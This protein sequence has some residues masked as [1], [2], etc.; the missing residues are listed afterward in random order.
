ME[1]KTKQEII[2]YIDLLQPSLAG[3][4]LYYCLPFRKKVVLKNMNIVFIDVLDQ[5]QIKNLALAFYSNIAKSL[6]ENLM[7]RF[8]SE[9]KIKSKAKVLGTEYIKQVLDENK[10]VLV[11]TG[12]FGNWE[13]A[14]IAGI[15][16]FK[17]LQGRFY[18]IR[19]L[20]VNKFFEKLLFS[21]YYNAGLNVIPKKN[22]LIKACEALEENSAVV[23]VMDQ[24]GCIGSK[25]GIKANFFGKPAGTYRS[26]A[27]I[28]RNMEVP[29]V[30]AQ[31]Y[32]KKNGTHVLEFHP[33]L[34]WIDAPKGREALLKNT[35]HYN[36][37]LEGMILKYPEQWLWMHKR[38]KI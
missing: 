26:L 38:W 31:S 33:P 17:M 16:N 28:A 3:K 15:L 25:D 29:V 36:H 6:K 8:W 32:R 10:G 5:K 27:T 13:F 7:M 22:A 4:F 24:H 1:I 21:R 30:P 18:F 11:L 2:K 37:V 14:P 34:K 9:E 35:Q 23:F 20:I 12:H 19:K